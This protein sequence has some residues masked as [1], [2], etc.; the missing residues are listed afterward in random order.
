MAEK[1][2][3]RVPYRITEV[4]PDLPALLNRN[5]EEIERFLSPIQV[6]IRENRQTWTQFQVWER[7]WEGEVSPEAPLQVETFIP[8]DA[9]IVEARLHLRLKP[10][11]ST[12]GGIAEGGGGVTG[13]GLTSLNLD[14]GTMQID[15]TQNDGGQSIQAVPDHTHP[16]DTGATGAA[17]GHGHVM[18]KHGHAATLPGHDHAIVPHSH[19]FSLGVTLGPLPSQVYVKIN[20]VDRTSELGGPFNDSVHSLLVT[21]YLAANRWNTFEFSSATPG[22]IAAT[23]FLRCLVQ[24]PS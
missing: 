20:D 7:G 8:A 3:F 10:F 24:P 13:L 17:G 4:G 16:L 2:S 18:Y 19:G 14:A 21:S 22:R 12:L 15:T 5:F 1:P 9:V 6:L 23:L 11:R